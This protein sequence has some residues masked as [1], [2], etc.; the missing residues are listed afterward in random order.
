MPLSVPVRRFACGALLGAAAF[1]T[2]AALSPT[3][4]AARTAPAPRLLSARCYPLASCAAPSIV[5]AGG[6]MLLRGTRFPPR[7]RVVFP[8]RGG[9]VV[10]QTVRRR[11]A[12]SLVVRVPSAAR[13]GRVRLRTLGGRWSN[14]SGPVTVRA[15]GGA[16]VQ[17]PS[18]TPSGTAFDGD[19]MWIWQ[20]WRSEGGSIAAIARRAK[21]AGVETVFIKSSD[22]ASMWKQFTPQL[23]A[24]LKA[25]G[26]AVCAWPYVYGKNPV[27]EAR[28]SV[29]AVQR[30]ADCLAI[31]AEGEYEGRYRS[32]RTYIRLLRQGVGA[33]YPVSLA[34]LPYVDYHGAFPYSVFLG[35]GGAQFNQ[36]QM[37][38][39]AIGVSVGRVY[40]HTYRWNRIYQRP[41]VPLGQTWMSPSTSELVR[42][43]SLARAFGAPGLSWWDWQE[44]GASGW[45]ALAAP[46]P[47]A[48][49]PG[50]PGWPPLRRGSRGDFVVWLQQHL[51]RAGASVAQ[52][53]VYGART[54]TAVR[55]FQLSRGLTP[56]G[57]MGAA[58]WR[59]LL[60]LSP[61]EP[62]WAP[63]GSG[64]SGG[65]GGA[66]A[67]SAAATARRGA[68]ASAW[69]VGRSEF[70][71]ARPPK[72]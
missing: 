45:R 60:R 56:T 9:G 46:L 65:A 11:S 23:V 41:I 21:A 69:V 13:S 52:D 62:D 68:P 22:G 67:S 50:D 47:A 40:D 5:T 31:D 17:A 6:R 59:A 43:R 61:A 64:G 24:A 55:T 53:G 1:A 29:R 51:E 2:P 48:P 4:A 25:R 12:T 34:G 28:N 42:F 49:Q 58:T 14:H 70:R 20:T 8:R 30:G 71:R 66:A 44:T 37:Y 16:R 27:A 63:A 18:G 57:I 38:W 54:S 72:R 33:R 36:P 32:A 3:A 15:R 35:P 19:G 26:L 39:K 7:L 10:A